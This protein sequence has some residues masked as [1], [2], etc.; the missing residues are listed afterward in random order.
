MR[1][2]DRAL[3]PAGEET[4]CLHCLLP[5]K[6]DPS[7]TDQLR[8]PRYSETLKSRTVKC[9]LSFHR[10][11]VLNSLSLGLDF[12][13]AVGFVLYICYASILCLAYIVR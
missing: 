9:F 2:A 1:P 7:V 11:L 12:V 6:H 4:S 10:R 3:L 13:L 5:D 8:Y